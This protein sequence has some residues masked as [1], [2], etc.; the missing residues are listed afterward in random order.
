MW[1]NDL[2]DYERLYRAFRQKN[3]YRYGLL[4]KNGYIIKPTKKI[5]AIPLPEGVLYL[6]KH[7]TKQESLNEA[8]KNSLKENHEF[9][10]DNLKHLN[11]AI[12]LQYFTIRYD[13]KF[14]RV[15][16][17]PNKRYKNALLKELY[18][19]T[20]TKYPYRRIFFGKVNQI[21]RKFKE[22]KEHSFMTNEQEKSI[23]QKARRWIIEGLTSIYKMKKKES[24]EAYRKFAKKL[25]PYPIRKKEENKKD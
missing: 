20:H 8:L 15:L 22:L 7:N 9:I 3:N 10:K 19:I 11:Q 13:D 14:K 17:Q 21:M 2:K 6:F 24:L 18:K 5:I 12:H 16:L 1:S 25:Y 4:S 23:N